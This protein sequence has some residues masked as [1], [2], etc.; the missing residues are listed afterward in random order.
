MTRWSSPRP[1]FQNYAEGQ[2]IN[3]E[4]ERLTSAIARAAGEEPR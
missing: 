4:R 2:W 3:K 1:F